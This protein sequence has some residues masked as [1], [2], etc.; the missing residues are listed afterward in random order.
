MYISINLTNIIKQVLFN[1][2]HF[3]TFLTQR[4]VIPYELI[5]KKSAAT[6][7]DEP[8]SFKV[9]NQYYTNYEHNERI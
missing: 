6:S 9:D 8:N 3:H 1:V 7:G 2:S 4:E 5:K